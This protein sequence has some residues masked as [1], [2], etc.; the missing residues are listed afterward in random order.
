MLRGGRRG[1][2][3]IRITG[4]IFIKVIPI[5][6]DTNLA[7]VMTRNFIMSTIVARAEVGI[8]ASMGTPA[9]KDGTMTPVMVP[10]MTD[11]T[12]DWSWPST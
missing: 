6:A 1:I 11:E 5:G 12:R 8:K 4:R 10:A 2:R 7:A 3:E 9:R